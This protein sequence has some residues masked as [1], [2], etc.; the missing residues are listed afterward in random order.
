MRRK[1]VV[2]VCMIAMIACSLSACN[3]EEP[4]ADDPGT[5]ESADTGEDAED[6]GEEGDT[7]DAP[8]GSGDTYDDYIRNAIANVDS[9]KPAIG[10]EPAKE[11]PAPVTPYPLQVPTQAPTI[12]PAAD[13]RET[14]PD[15][16]YSSEDN[17]DPTDPSSSS[18]SGS[19]SSTTDPSGTPTPTPT[20]YITPDEFEVG[21]CCIYING[22][23]DNAFGT[24]VVTAINKTRKDLGYDELIKNTGLTT[25]ADRR[26]REV[27]AL[28]SHQRPNGQMYFTLAPEHFKAELIIVGSQKA[29]DAV[30]TLIKTDPA[31]RYL[32]FTEKYRSV[33]ASSFKTNGLHFTVVAFGL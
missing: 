31:S 23:S 18:S 9:D 21:K 3:P 5:E 22:E 2:I 30:D 14:P 19:S 4:A 16:F 28:R 29:E 11:T 6:T 10:S 20:P 7:D 15:F 25:C 27:A 1:L 32:V 17:P 12:T 24:E 8:A 26:T 13:T 33:G